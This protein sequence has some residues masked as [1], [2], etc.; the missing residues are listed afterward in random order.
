MSNYVAARVVAVPVCR[1][2]RPARAHPSLG[3]PSGLVEHGVCTWKCI[4]RGWKRN[5]CR[6]Q[7]LICGWK[8]IA[9]VWKRRCADVRAGTQAPPLRLS[10][11]KPQKNKFG[12]CRGFGKRQKKIL[13]LAGSSANGKK[14]FWDL[15]RVRQTLKK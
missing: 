13:R 3:V 9:L 15:P 8:C 10:L 14:R 12:T 6:W 11:S 2:A 5:V 7:H 4:I 1:P